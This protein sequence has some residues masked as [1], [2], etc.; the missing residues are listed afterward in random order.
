[1]AL[2][3]F[4]PEELVGRPFS[5]LMHPEDAETVQ[6]MCAAVFQSKGRIAPWTVEFRATHKSG[7]PIWMECRPTL[8]SDPATGRYVGITDVISDV[9]QRKALEAE[10]RAARAQAEA[11]A[12]VKAEFLANMSHELRTPLTSILGFTGLAGEQPELSALS[13]TYVGRVRDASQALLSTVNDILDFSKLEAGQV[14]IHPQP[15]NVSRL[16]RATLELFTPQAGAKDLHLTLDDKAS[17]EDLVVAADPDRLRQILLNFVGN[18]VKFTEQGGVTLRTSYDTLQQSLRVEVIDTGAGIAPAKQ[19]MLFQRFSQIDGSLTRAKGGTGLGLAICKGLVEA[20]GGEIGVESR[21]GEGSRFW[22]NLPVA[23]ALMPAAETASDAELRPAFEGVRVLVADDHETNRELARL[24][25]AG[26]GA[27]VTEAADGE[28]A[29][30]LASAWPFDVILMDLRMP[31]LDGEGALRR[32]H[33]EPGPND[34]TPILAFTADATPDLADRLI[35]VGFEA[36]VAKPLTPAALLSAIARATA[37][38]PP[39]IR[40]CADAG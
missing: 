36:V 25:L 18:A 37:F 39:P 9:T 4:R 11:A 30:S 10:L 24:F 19:A 3:G 35:A 32:I 29:A 6:A 8:V 40:D 27:E 34:A 20:M 12:Q 17:G 23:P 2:T 16:A 7:Q 5:A 31:R 28:E 38:D 15:M 13:R 22:F 21:P 14:A 26:V 33:G 1:L